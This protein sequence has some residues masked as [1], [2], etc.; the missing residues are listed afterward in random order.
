MK[1]LTPNEVAE[2]LTLSRATVAR[3]IQ[4]HVL[5]VIVLRKGPRQ[6]TYRV[7]QDALD[8]FI[9]ARERQG[10]NVGVDTTTLMAEHHR[11]RE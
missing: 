1:L 9:M 11:R 2:Q 4:D 7:R 6:A 3:M 5:P 10:E 8:K